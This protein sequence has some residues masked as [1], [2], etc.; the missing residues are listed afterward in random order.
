MKSPDVDSFGKYFFHTCDQALMRI[1]YLHLVTACLV[2]LV[3]CALMPKLSAAAPKDPSPKWLLELKPIQE[4]K[5]IQATLVNASQRGQWAIQVNDGSDAG[6]RE[7]AVEWEVQ[8]LTNKEWKPVPAKPRGRCGLYAADWH[9][10]AIEVEAGKGLELALEWLGPPSYQFA[11][12]DS[13]PHRV[14]LH[15]SYSGGKRNKGG[16]SSPAKL[17]PNF[18]PDYEVVS[19]WVDL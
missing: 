10:D 3:V 15:Y 14:R 7:P 11:A 1:T 16:I 6:W 13:R 19:E 8:V 4:G 18:G 12:N 2:A 5:K 9:K 17:N